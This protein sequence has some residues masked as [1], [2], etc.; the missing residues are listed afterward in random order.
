MSNMHYEIE[1]SSKGK[2]K[3]DKKQNVVMFEHVQSYKINGKVI[4]DHGKYVGQDYSEGKKSRL[5]KVDEFLMISALSLY[6]ITYIVIVII[7][8]LSPHA[9]TGNMIAIAGFLLAIISIKPIKR[10]LNIH[11]VGSPTYKKAFINIILLFLAFALAFILDQ[12]HYLI[13][14]A[15][16]LGM[17]AI[18]V[19]IIIG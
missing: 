6:L 3:I 1:A 5:E 11:L 12:F 15:N 13:P 16:A 4:F 18:L 17:I 2:P 9:L 8:M 19:S 10:I 7:D 14:F